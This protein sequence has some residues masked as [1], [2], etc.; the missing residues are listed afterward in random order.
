MKNIVLIAI[1]GYAITFGMLTKDNNNKAYT[2]VT[3]DVHGGFKSI[4]IPTTEPVLIIPK[5]KPEIINIITPREREYV[6][7][8]SK[9]R[10]K[11]LTILRVVRLISIGIN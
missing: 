11:I 4:P 8:P 3:V 5:V 6:I 9:K 7:V 1:I 10:P 2:M